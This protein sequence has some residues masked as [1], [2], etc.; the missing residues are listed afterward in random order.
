MMQS[1]GNILRGSEYQQTLKDGRWT[2]FANASNNPH[3][4][5]NQTTKRMNPLLQNALNLIAEEVFN[6]A[7]A[8][9]FH[10]SDEDEGQFLTR[11]VA[12]IHGEVS[13]LWE[14]YRK[15]ELRKPCDKN[16]FEPLNCADEELA[17]IVIRAL[18]TAARLKIDI[19][20]AVA[21]KHAYNV[22]REYRH[23]G[24]AA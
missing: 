16:T 24:K 22:Q 13:E 14:A 6:N 2:A 11:T 20:R 10:D 19:G 1:V 5:F 21:I 3:R 17:D 18:D 12:N 4:N 7:R 15:H 8:H 23:G 9:G